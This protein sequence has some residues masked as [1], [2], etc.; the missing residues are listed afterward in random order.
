MT[1]LLLFDIDG[2]LLHVAEEAAFARAFRELCG[3]D[4]DL[5]W[6]VDA[7]VSDISFI[8]AVLQRAIGRV[9]SEGEIAAATDLFVRYLEEG[10]TGGLLPVRTVRGAGGFLRACA[11][12]AVAI[13][14]GCVE[15]SAR[16]KLRQA[17][18]EGY[19]PC[20]GFSIGERRRAEI[21]MRA[22]AAAEGQY[23]RRFAPADIVSFG[24]GPWDVQAAREAGVRFIGINESD[25]GR[26]RLRRAGASLVVSDFTDAA[27]IER[28]LR[29]RE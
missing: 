16:V 4:V 28:A 11:G 26:D 14:T 6:P 18:F 22:I 17:G 7:A 15:P 9:P 13:A 1:Q 21:L 3:D 10:I 8:S 12:S 20:G 2:T 24:D 25:H 5:S 23:D 27:A 19:F 29:S